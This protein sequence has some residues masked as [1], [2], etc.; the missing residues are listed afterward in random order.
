MYAGYGWRAARSRH[1]GGVNVL[2]A[3]GSGQFVE[4][5]VDPAVWKALATRAGGEVAA[6]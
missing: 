3:D 4:D 6:P 2:M 5:G 1:P